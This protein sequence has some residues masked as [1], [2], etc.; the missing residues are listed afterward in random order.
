ME[1]DIK[2]Q[3]FIYVRKSYV[4]PHLV[5]LIIIEGVESEKLSVNISMKRCGS[6]KVTRKEAVSAL[7]MPSDLAS[8]AT[9]IFGL[10][11]KLRW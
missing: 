9:R 2:Q 4:H 1:A 7:T 10:M 6:S 8:G 11:G 5:D 3:Y